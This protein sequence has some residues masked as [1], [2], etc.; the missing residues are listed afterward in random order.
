MRLAWR[1]FKAIPAWLWRFIHT[2]LLAFLQH[3]FKTLA[4][5]V[6]PALLIGSAIIFGYN[7]IADDIFIDDVEIQGEAKDHGFTSEMLAQQAIELMPS[8]LQER[9]A[10]LSYQQPYLQLIERKSDRYKTEYVCQN[11]LPLLKDEY[12][13]FLP[14]LQKAAMSS[15]TLEQI[16]S[17]QNLSIKKLAYWVRQIVGKKRPKQLKSLVWWEKNQYIMKVHPTPWVEDIQ[18][19][20]ERL[21]DAPRLLANSFV[22]YLFPELVAMEKIAQGFRQKDHFEFSR[23]VANN[24]LADKQK[25][26]LIENTIIGGYLENSK[27]NADIN[28]KYK[29]FR[30][31]NQALLN[32][33]DFSSWGAQAAVIQ[34]L[35]ANRI[36]RAEC[37]DACDEKYIRAK[38]LDPYRA[39]LQKTSAGQA[40]LM[41]L[42]T[43]AD[44]DNF[45]NRL[46][47][48]QYEEITP[49]DN[50][51]VNKFDVILLAVNRLFNEQKYD[52][53]LQII[54]N[55]QVL[56][57]VGS[58][59]P[60]TEMAFREIHA[61]LHVLQG[62]FGEYQ[63]LLKENF[64]DLPCAEWD[65]TSFL[66][67]ELKNNKAFNTAQ[68]EQLTRL[69]S[70]SY[71]RLEKNGI[72]NFHF[73]NNWGNFEKRNGHYES[74]YHKYDQALHYEGDHTWALL[75]WGYAAVGN[76]DYPLAREKFLESLQR[77]TIPETVYGLLRTLAAQND[78]KVYLDNF[79]RYFKKLKS[80]KLVERSMIEQHAI[81]ISCQLTGKPPKVSVLATNEGIIVEDNNKTIPRSEYIKHHCLGGGKAVTHN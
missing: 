72:K 73:Y 23:N 56:K 65:T 66:D 4:E 9:F 10:D 55:P 30:S 43:E 32:Q 2:R 37:V 25:S 38:Y 34:A 74:A 50:G 21:A 48:L 31:H 49:N 63:Q 59:S 27:T 42:G 40:V 26:L 79:E 81:L 39:E 70:E 58:G 57:L 19:P 15:Q 20:F 54:D 62:D 24:F 41:M 7:I 76:Q 61:S 8:I 51:T 52:K 5:L 28:A 29:F 3:P 77:G 17:S 78:R 35:I 44:L 16:V 33:L 46:A 71:S 45:I 14:E 69:L 68:Q 64:G 36:V 18:V 22:D 53:V 80:F 6:G 60:N 11:N 1:W 47:N 12:K 67:S 13:F 75:N